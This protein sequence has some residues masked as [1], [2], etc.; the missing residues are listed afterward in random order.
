MPDVLPDL[1]GHTMESTI[2]RVHKGVD[3]KLLFKGKSRHFMAPCAA[4]DSIGVCL[5]AD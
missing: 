4:A 1:E 2:P 3:E 5:R